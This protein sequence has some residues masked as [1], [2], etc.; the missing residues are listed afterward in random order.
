M[1]KQSNELAEQIIAKLHAKNNSSSDATTQHTGNVIAKLEKQLDRE[2]DA[3]KKA[4]LRKQIQQK[5]LDK[6]NGYAN[7]SIY[8]ADYYKQAINDIN[9]LKDYI[10]REK[11]RKTSKQQILADSQTTAKAILQNYRQAV[12]N[13]IEDLETWQKNYIKQFESSKKEYDNPQLELLHRQDFNAKLNAMNDRQLSNYI[14]NLNEHGQL[15]V[16][17]LNTLMGAVKG[18]SRLYNI[19]KVYKDSNNIGSE[20]KNTK[21]WKAVNSALNTLGVYEQSDGIYTAPDASGR[22]HRINLLNLGNEETIGYNDDDGQQNT[23]G[24]NGRNILDF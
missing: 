13:H 3:Y 19:L 20:Y 16:Y 6:L 8:E 4:E 24:N 11:K 21:E 12:H 7:I 2:D 23:I 22:P 17:E 18:K 15:T 5:K 14:S 9:K 10:T 1:D